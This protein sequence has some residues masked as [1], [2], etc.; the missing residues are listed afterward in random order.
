[1]TVLSSIWHGGGPLHRAVAGLPPDT[2]AVLLVSEVVGEHGV[3]CVVC[4]FPVEA[5]DIARDPCEVL[6]ATL[7]SY[8]HPRAGELGDLNLPL[9]CHTGHLN[10]G[11]KEGVKDEVGYWKRFGMY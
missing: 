7:W 9:P 1:M 5:G 4:G 2:H 6:Q 8:A 3:I 10:R 11:W